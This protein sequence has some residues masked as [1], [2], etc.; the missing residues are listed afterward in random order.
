MDQGKTGRLIA[1]LRKEK[2]M[3]QKQ[4]AEQ[5]G[6]T[7]R[8]VSKWENG[9][10]LP[11]PDL[12][13][14]LGRALECRVEDLL[15]GERT[16]EAG[17]AEA[18]LRRSYEEL[19]AA[20]GRR[21][22]IAKAAGMILAGCCLLLAVLLACNRTFLRTAYRSELAENISIAVPRFSYY[23][24]EGGLDLRLVK[25]KTLKQPDEV[26]VFIRQYLAGLERV[27]GESGTYYYNKSKDFT[28]WQYA[29]NNDGIGFVNTIYLGYADGFYDGEI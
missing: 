15:R 28:V 27:R 20:Q 18:A 25:L 2:G 21:R 11:E 13:L 14:P 10:G 3:T 19:L 5:L 1:A 16:E 29:I 9:R 23:R 4:L 6:I 26:E 17:G 24:S 12:L 7:D 8:A 22:R